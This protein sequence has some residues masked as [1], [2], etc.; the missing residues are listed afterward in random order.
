MDGTQITEAKALT[1]APRAAKEDKMSPIAE[2][3]DARHSSGVLSGHFR[4][5]TRLADD[6]VTKRRVARAVTRAKQG[7]R[8]AL[9]YL[10]I[11]YA[12]NVYGY[13]MSI[14]RDEH[15]AE[16]VTQLVF[17]KLMTVLHKYEQREVPF[18]SWLMRLAHNAAYDHLR[19]R[20]PTPVDEV[21]SPDDRMDVGPS[22]DVQ[23]VGQALAALPEDQRTVVVL[24]HLV[25]LTPGEIADRLGRTENSVHGLHHRGRRALQQ[26]LRRLECGP[27]TVAGNRNRHPVP[28]A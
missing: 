15:E 8:E 12:D 4:R 23:I 9:R 11:R 3:N 19:R 10:Y 21:R 28:A 16:D 2:F 7:D 1:H 6:E 20:L 22:G 5:D 25:G 17:A 26:E 14:L 27:V 13:V 24:R 18:T